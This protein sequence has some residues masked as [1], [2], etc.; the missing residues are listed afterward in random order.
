MLS[1][2]MDDGHDDIFRKRAGYIDE[3]ILLSKF[4][5]MKGKIYSKLSSN[6]SAKDS[7]RSSSSIFIMVSAD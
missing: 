3:L 1:H 4:F 7:F 5:G 2:E 6:L